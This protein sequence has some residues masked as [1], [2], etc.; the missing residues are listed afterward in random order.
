MPIVMQDIMITL[1]AILRSLPVGTN[2]ALLHFM[3]MLV[4]GK[5]LNSRGALFPGLLSSGLS[6]AEIRRA[7]SAFR[8]GSWGIDE[9]LANWRQY[10]LEQGE[11]RA[12]QY[13][14]YRLK[15]VDLT[16]NSRRLAVKSSA[17]LI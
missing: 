5:L 9:L 8:Y 4:S 15:A 13:E 7:W 11:W 16:S 12:H 14:G 2:L 6:T 17:G 10:V 1:C 3:W